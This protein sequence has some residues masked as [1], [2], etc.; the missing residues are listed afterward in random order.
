MWCFFALPASE[1]GASSFYAVASLQTIKA[2]LLRSCKI[3][4]VGDRQNF[5]LR[6]SLKIVRIRARFVTNTECRF[7]LNLRGFALSCVL[8]NWAWECSLTLPNSR[9]LLLGSKIV[10]E[11]STLEDPSWMSY[12]PLFFRFLVQFFCNSEK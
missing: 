11:F 7:N 10:R 9:L 8:L 4:F 1:F 3:R 12:L 6:T 5:K 2:Q